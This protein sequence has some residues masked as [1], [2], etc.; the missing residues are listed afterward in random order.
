[1]NK[2]I[3][4]F[5]I[6]S[7]LLISLN[8]IFYQQSVQAKDHHDGCTIGVAAG[9]ATSDGR[10]LLWKTRDG[11]SFNNAIAYISNQRYKFITVINAGDW[12][13]VAWMGVNEK[14]FAILDSDVYD[15]DRGLFGYS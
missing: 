11:S 5:D 14:G 4:F 6:V 12:F 9:S 8:Q 1:M 10:P 7:I 2:S 3:T 15:L 13:P